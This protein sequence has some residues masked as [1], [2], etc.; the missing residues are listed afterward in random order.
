MKNV[1]NIIRRAI[2]SMVGKASLVS[3]VITIRFLHLLAMGL[4]FLPRI[5]SRVR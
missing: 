4:V 1:Y 2:S 3:D 5:C